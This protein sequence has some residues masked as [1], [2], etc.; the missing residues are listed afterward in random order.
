MAGQTTLDASLTFD[1]VSEASSRAS[2]R[3][4][5]LASSPPQ[6][7][8]PSP[9]R[10]AAPLRGCSHTPSPLVQS[11]LASAFV[12][13][14]PSLSASTHAV[15]LNDVNKRLLQPPSRSTS[16]SASSARSTPN[17]DI[18]TPPMP[19]SRPSKR[20]RPP[21]AVEVKRE[22]S[23]AR[24]AQK[25][26]RTRSPSGE[27]GR[28]SSTG[29]A[30]TMDNAT[31]SMEEDAAVRQTRETEEE[32][33]CDREEEDLN[34]LFEVAGQAPKPKADLRSWE[35]L[36]KKIN[37]EL[38]LILRNF[39]N[40]RIK[41]KQRIEASQHIAEAWHEGEGVHFARQV[42]ALARHYQLF[43]EL[44]NELRGGNHGHSL[45]NDER[46]QAALRQ[47]LTNLPTGEVTPKLF[48]KELCERILPALG[49]VLAKWISDR[50][51]R[52]WLVKLGWR[53]TR[54]KKGVYMD[55]HECPDVVQYHDDVFLPTMAACEKYMVQWIV[56]ESGE[57]L[58][59]D[60]VLGPGDKRIVPLLHDESSL[61]AGEYKTNVWLCVG[62]TKL[63]KK[64]RG[65]IIHVSDFIDEELGCLVV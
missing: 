36:R 63:Q 46:V 9:A 13:R 55:G 14:R 41:G 40:L 25:C 53:R 58:R 26:A 60:P 51:A 39:A 3:G 1:T 29:D 54:L 65:R 52:R 12:L 28:P 48:R 37:D 27:R 32:K 34:G 6:S 50:T 18:G 11:T 10:S 59:V 19:A 17:V 64:G 8:S 47:Y 24:S 15:S 20:A 35:E 45:I 62:E 16:R 43:E 4:R 31:A 42:R 61:H 33:Q 7:L 23:T 5:S 44:P 30:G 56:Q 2:L 38:L 22:P 57:L 49:I 21:E